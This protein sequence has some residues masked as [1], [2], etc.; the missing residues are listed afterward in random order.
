MEFISGHSSDNLAAGGDP[1]E[2]IED[3]AA[4]GI[5]FLRVLATPEV[6]SDDSFHL[7]D[8]SLG[9]NHENAIT[10]LLDHRLVFVMLVLNVADHHL[11]DVFEGDKTV[12]T[13]IFI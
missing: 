11:D 6:S 1:A 13:A 4:N 2:S 8:F 10:D 7:I 3:H 9:I 5:H 12:G